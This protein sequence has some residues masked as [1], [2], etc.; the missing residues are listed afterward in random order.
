VLKYWGDP[1]QMFDR[2]LKKTEKFEAEEKRQN[3]ILKRQKQKDRET[4]G[5]DSDDKKSVSGPGVY[6]ELAEIK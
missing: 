6:G 5:Y 2:F 3:D 4:I 1:E